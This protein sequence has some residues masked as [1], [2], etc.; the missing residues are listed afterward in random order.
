ML[1]LGLQDAGTGSFG[2]LELDIGALLLGFCM[3]IGCVVIISA[4]LYGVIRRLNLTIW[5]LTAQLGNVSQGLM[6]KRTLEESGTRAA[7]V[8][9]QALRGLRPVTHIPPGPPEGK[10]ENVSAKTVAAI[11]EQVEK[12]KRGGVTVTRAHV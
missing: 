2:I 11:N 7:G 6:V 4:L 9:G 1:V 8:M 12:D 10:N 5:T 3:G